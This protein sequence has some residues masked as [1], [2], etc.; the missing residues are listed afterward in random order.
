MRNSLTSSGSGSDATS[1]RRRR[2]DRGG[3]K[4]GDG[5]SSQAGEVRGISHRSANGTRE[6]ESARLVGNLL[7]REGEGSGN[8]GGGTREREGHA[9]H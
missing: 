3:R 1:C 5:G 4:D 8:D 2:G 6:G 7:R 9:R